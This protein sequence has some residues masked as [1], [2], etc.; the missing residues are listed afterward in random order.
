VPKVQETSVGFQA[1]PGIATIMDLLSEWF[2]GHMLKVDKEY[3]GVLQENGD[4]LKIRDLLA[5]RPA[6]EIWRVFFIW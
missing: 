5:V 1:A 3:S 4:R 2:M 6:R